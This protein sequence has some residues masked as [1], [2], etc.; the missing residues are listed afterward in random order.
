M[1]GFEL[2]A[3]PLFNIAFRLRVASFLFCFL[4][5]GHPRFLLLERRVTQIVSKSLLSDRSS[6][7][8]MLCFHLFSAQL[9]G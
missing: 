4:K 2:S 7:F 5:T 6:Y 1:L 3:F 9:L 8:H